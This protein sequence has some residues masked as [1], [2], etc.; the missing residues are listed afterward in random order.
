[1]TLGGFH[2]KESVQLFGQLVR[3]MESRINRYKTACQTPKKIVMLHL[4]V[5]DL[6]VL[7]TDFTYLSRSQDHR[8]VEVG[9]NLQ[10]SSSPT[11]QL[12]LG[13][14]S[15]TMSRWHLIISK[16]LDSTTSGQTMPVKQYFLTFR[17]FLSAVS[18]PV[19]GQH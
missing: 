14:L 18:S 3:Q 7:N 1:M 17:G 16:D 5:V 15:S 11:P 2:C 9:R 12:K 10:S 6:S 4:S 19:S 13:Q 8:M